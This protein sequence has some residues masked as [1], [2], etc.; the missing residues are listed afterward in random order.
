MRYTRISLAALTAALTLGLVLNA[1]A[2]NAGGA[3]DKKAEAKGP[4]PDLKRGLMD[5]TKLDE[6]TIDKVLKALGPAVS[7]QARAGR[8]IEF[9]GVGTSRW[10]GSPST[11]TWSTA[12]RP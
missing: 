4:A 8:Q 1:E 2:Q 9:P 12:G 5:K 3:R 7:E 6:K 10:C 11:R